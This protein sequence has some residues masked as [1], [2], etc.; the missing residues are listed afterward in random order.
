MGNK[1]SDPMLFVL[2][3]VLSL[4][5]SLAHNSRRKPVLDRIFGVFGYSRTVERLG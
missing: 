5:R 2:S 4:A 3:F 1:S